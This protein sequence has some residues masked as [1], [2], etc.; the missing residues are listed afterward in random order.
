MPEF[1]EKSKGK[2]ETCKQPLQ[3]LFNMVIKAIDI[4]ILCG[5]MLSLFKMIVLAINWGAWPDF[6][7]AA[8]R[9]TGGRAAG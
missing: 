1:S 9:R 8:G 4:T 5:I 7:A 3:R 2:L 6:N